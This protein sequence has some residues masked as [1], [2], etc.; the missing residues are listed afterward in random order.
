MRLSISN[1]FSTFFLQ[2]VIDTL[3]NKRQKDYIQK[4]SFCLFKSIYPKQ[5]KTYEEKRA[6]ERQQDDEP[7]Y[8]TGSA[9]SVASIGLVGLVAQDRRHELCVD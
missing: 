8:L 2:K 9:I 5:T 1:D 3:H 7:T 4:K 6:K